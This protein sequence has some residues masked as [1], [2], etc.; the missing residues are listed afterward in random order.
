MNAP[1]AEAIRMLEHATGGTFDVWGVAGPTNRRTRTA[2]M[3]TLTGEKT[4]A[5]RCG[6]NA[7]Q[8]EFYRQVR[9]EMGRESLGGTPRER[10]TTFADFCR[11]AV[12]YA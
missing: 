4:P 7:L 10:Q 9:Q 3:R 12:A 8:D 2:I 11:L 1:L 6:V 5:A